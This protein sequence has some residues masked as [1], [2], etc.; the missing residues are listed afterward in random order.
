MLLESIF[1]GY[2]YVFMISIWLLFLSAWCFI[3]LFM[4]MLLFLYFYDF[5]RFILLNEIDISLFLIALGRVSQ[6]NRRVTPR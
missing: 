3:V 2:I 1:Y 4:I 5:I 6:A